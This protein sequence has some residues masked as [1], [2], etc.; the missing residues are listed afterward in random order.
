MKWERKDLLDLELQIDG[1]RTPADWTWFAG[2]K[3]VQ[4][5]P[6]YSQT[7]ESSQNQLVSHN[8]NLDW[9]NYNLETRIWVTCHLELAETK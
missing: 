5:R 6:Q 9:H 8:Y 4:N 2:L 7:T 1:T 3:C